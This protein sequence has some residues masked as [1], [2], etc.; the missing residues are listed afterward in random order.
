MPVSWFDSISWTVEI[1]ID[2]LGGAVA[3]Y[4]AKLAST[5][6]TTTKTWV[7]VSSQVVDFQT[8]RGRSDELDEYA[9]GTARVRLLNRD[10]RF[11]PTYTLGPYYGSL[12]PRRRIRIRCT[13]GGITYGVWFGLIN[14]WPQSYD[15]RS[16]GFVDLPCTDLTFLLSV[17]DLPSWW[18][19]YVEEL[20]PWA[21]YRLGTDGGLDH[22][23]NGR[24][25]TVDDSGASPTTVDVPV[26]RAALTG[27][28]R[29]LTMRTSAS[30]TTA[31]ATT[32]VAT[33]AV[34]EWPADD[35]RT[36]TLSSS[37]DLS[38]RDIA[39]NVPSG[40]GGMFV[41]VWG[42]RRSAFLFGNPG[43]G[44]VECENPF[45]V[46][47]VIPDDAQPGDR[48]Q[49]AVTRSGTTATLY[50]N[51]QPIDSD[52][53]STSSVVL[54]PRIL[55]DG[56]IVDEFVVFD[57]ALTGVE[58]ARLAALADC[59]MVPGSTLTMRTD[60]WADLVLDAIDWPAADRMIGSLPFADATFL[61][62]A[63]RDTPHDGSPATAPDTGSVLAILRQLERTEQGR[64][65]IDRD[66]RVVFRTRTW[67]MSDSRTIT[68]QQTFGDAAGELGYVDLSTNESGER[69]RNVWIVGDATAS[70]SASIT[71]YGRST[72]IVD[73]VWA[74]P[75][76]ADSLAAWLVSRYK[77]PS[78]RVVDLEI[79]VRAS[80]ATLAPAVLGLELGDLVT[81]RR[82]PQSIG[83]VLEVVATVEGISHT[84]M[85]EGRWRVRIQT[86]KRMVA[87]GQTVA[88]VGVATVGGTAVIGP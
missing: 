54:Q 68:S 56:F 3:W 43:T 74:L 64:C 2:L 16:L 41:F 69:L 81:V 55:G 26:A 22:S 39:A 83:A 66:G 38:E 73:G 52:T 24:D 18:E 61:L 31:T 42:D 5:P 49:I 70:D 85:A 48:I 4:D 87:A 32:I 37:D 33:V 27:G 30:S 53:V 59:A 75:H 47:G 65:F 58:V 51:G 8:R 1:E 14:D 36:L 67:S 21:W 78:T 63:G 13:Y 77:D 34:A 84:V 40:R 28:S 46:G 62:S 19:A 29:N 57:R 7:D 80:T 9:A 6:T 20:G 76:E 72:G 15:G 71:T 45:A 86:G 88:V 35:I 10:R 82:R 12:K 50:V 23:G 44:G 79:E 11:D 25:G 17:A 60:E